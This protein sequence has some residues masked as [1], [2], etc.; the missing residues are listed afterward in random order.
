M[1]GSMNSYRYECELERMGRE[2]DMAIDEC[3]EANGY[4]ESMTAY[5]SELEEAVADLYGSVPFWKRGK[6]VA[7]HPVIA[8]VL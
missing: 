8:E 7:D 6:L 2:L 1:T 4:L 5:A 3:D